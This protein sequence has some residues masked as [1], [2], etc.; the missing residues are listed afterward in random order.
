MGLLASTVQE[1]LVVVTILRNTGRIA[2]MCMVR[3]GAECTE[4]E[5]TLEDWVKMSKE[6]PIET[7]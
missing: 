6:A 1:L 5:V 2:I 4:R 3:R 7:Q